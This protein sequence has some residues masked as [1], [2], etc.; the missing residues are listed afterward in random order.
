MYGKKFVPMLK[1]KKIKIKKLAYDIFINQLL[2][3]TYIIFDSFDKKMD[4]RAF[5]F[6]FSNAFGKSWHKRLIYQLCELT[7]LTDFLSNIKQKVDQISS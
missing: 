5:F 7:L 1:K 6:F 4:A 2:S 3:T